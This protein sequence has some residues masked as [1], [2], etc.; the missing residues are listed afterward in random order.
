MRRCSSPRSFHNLG[1]C[2]S[3]SVSPITD[4]D[5]MSCQAVQPAARILG[6]ATP[7]NS[8]PGN[9]RCR[10]SMS[11]APSAS[12]EVSPATSAM[13]MA[14]RSA[15]EAAGRLAD[16][17]DE[18]LELGLRLGAFAELLDRVGELQVGAVQ[19]TVRILEIADLLWRESAP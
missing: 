17:V 12:P 15:H 10:A 3:T 19:H 16:E 1:R 2:A 11:A 9:R 14:A 7:A 18:D 4:S 6:P 5:S 8:A 13:R